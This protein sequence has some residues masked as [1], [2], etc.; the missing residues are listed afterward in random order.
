MIAINQKYYE[1]YVGGFCYT[2]SVFFVNLSGELLIN[3]LPMLENL[4]VPLE[5]IFIY[6]GLRTGIFVDELPPPRILRFYY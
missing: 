5:A 3:D 4:L 1:L 2:K 6:D